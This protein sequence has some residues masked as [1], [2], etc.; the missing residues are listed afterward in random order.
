MEERCKVVNLAEEHLHRKQPKQKKW[1]PE[2]TLEMI[3]EKCLAFLCWQEDRQNVEKCKEY[4]DL[5]KKVRRAV[6]WDKE[7]WLDKTMQGMEEDMRCHWQRD[8]FKKMKQL[9]NSRVIPA[10]TILDETSLPLQKAEEKLARWSRH[11]ESV[12]NVHSTVVEEALAGLGDHSQMEE[13][14]VTREEVEK[15]VGKLRNG[16]SAGDDRIVSELLKNGGEAMINW[17]WELL[18]MVCRTRQAPSEWK[19]ATLV[20]LHKKKDKK[21]CDNYRGISLLNVPGKV[22]VLTLFE[23]L[24]T[25]IEP[26]LII[27][28]TQCGFRKG[29]STVNQI[30]VTNKVVEKAAA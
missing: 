10:D 16:K 3:E 29:H 20:P 13:P 28:D 18:Q 12:L 15:A 24:E 8:F 11:F 9:T 1:I 6:R 19:S 23:Q 17:L 7:K 14:E 30:W 27:M 21:V 5:C 25:I 22:L 4:V 26:Q 2:G